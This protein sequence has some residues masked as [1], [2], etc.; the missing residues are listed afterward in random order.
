MEFRG[1]RWRFMPS[2]TRILT[3]KNRLNFVQGDELHPD[4]FA[5]KTESE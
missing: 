3:E 5:V 2:Y 1:E 4:Q